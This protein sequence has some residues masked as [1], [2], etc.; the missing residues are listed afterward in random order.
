[1]SLTLSTRFPGGNAA[2][3]TIEENGP[4]PEIRFASDPC[5]GPEALWFCFRLE[6]TNPDPARHSK[7]RLVWN[8]VDTVLGAG[9]A[10]DC[11]PVCQ[12]PGQPWV[13]LRQGEVVRAADGQR[14]LSWL[15]PHP[16]PFVEIA[17]CFPYGTAEMD[18]VLDR[19]RG[20][21]QSCP[22]GLTQGARRIVRLHNSLGAPGGNQPGIYVVARQH[23]GETP[24]SWVLDGFLKH[25]AQV[26][27]AG[28]V[29]WVIPF[30]DMDGVVL[31]HYG[32]DAF[33]YDLNRAWGAPPMRRETGVI[34][35]DVGRWKACCRPVLALDFHAP[36]ACERDGVYAFASKDPDGPRAAEELKWCNVLQQELKAEFAAPE[37][38]R[39]AAYKSRWETP[40][41]AAFMRDE[42]GV[43]ALSVETPYS[44]A[45]GTL[46]TQNSYREIGRRLALGVMRRTG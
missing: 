35:C 41:F 28:Y 2:D 23:A 30:A 5:G 44:H 42:M 33:P 25:L 16:A 3:V 14:Q 39:V 18:A 36:G 13:R 19:S 43:P 10:P 31:G 6:E 12:S 21:W 40:N 34:R 11:V 22:I 38:K 17:F 32:K 15:I 20:Y 27:K 26:R 24:G 8:Y 46:L 9:E 37:F 1:M 45:A 29:V 4:V 7:V